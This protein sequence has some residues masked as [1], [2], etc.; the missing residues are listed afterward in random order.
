MLLIDL[1]NNGIYDDARVITGHKGL[2]REV[3]TVNIMDCPDIIRFLRPNE[4]LLTN[5][6]FMKQQPEMFIHLIKDMQ[7][8]HCSGLAI[9][10][11]RFELP[12]PDEILWEADRIEFPIIEISDVRLSLGEILQRS[13]SVILNNK[14]DELQYALSVHKKFSEIIMRGNGISG[15]IESL[16]KLFSSPVILLNNKWQTISAPNQ[17]A[18]VAELITSAVAT[19]HDLSDT[20]RPTSLCLINSSFRERCC[21]LIYPVKTYRHEGYLLSFHSPDQWT[22]LYGLT[23]EQASNVIGMEMTKSQAV[24]E[25][26]RRYKNEFFSDLI[27]GYITSEQEALN[28]GKRYGLIQGRACVVLAMRNDEVHY[29]HHRFPKYEGSAIQKGDSIMEQEEHYEHIKRLFGA[30]E[31]SFVMFTKHDTYCLLLSIPESGWDEA[32]LTEQVSGILK[33]LHHETGLCLSVGI[34]KQATNVLGVRHSYTEGVNA[35]QFGYRLKR[36]QFVQSYQAKDI[37]YLFHMLPQDELKQFHDATLNGLLQIA[38]EHEQKE[39][40]RTLNAFYD[41]QCQLVETSKQL[42]VHRNTVVYRLEK[43]EKLLGVKLK[44]PAESLRIRIAI[45]IEPLL[46]LS[47][48]LL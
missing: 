37:G 27:E 26:S 38:D 44:D 1:L 5:G 28:R 24:K 2:V 14:S 43:C 22:G 6:F 12:I 13:T 48:P 45:A 23:L 36:K 19:L 32:K 39:L 41:T 21:M 11:K 29:M 7:R 8:L 16:C 20:S 18:G 35:L 42:F 40:L 3:Q 47:R 30:L 9:K 31:H 4:L 34:G 10:T 25:R 33:Q 17:N 46:P 15:I